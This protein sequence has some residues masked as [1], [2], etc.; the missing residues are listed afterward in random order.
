MSTTP[1]P[2]HNGPPSEPS[3]ARQYARAETWVIEVRGDLDLDTLPPLRKALQAAAAT[4]P[5]S[6]L[7]LAG[8]TF[9]DSSALNLLLLS[10]QAT[11]LRLAA[12]AQALSR[13][14]RITGAD[15]VLH[16]YPSVEDAT[17]S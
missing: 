1:E 4:H 8:V 9:A 16:I 6:V 11:D 14:F 17:S 7:D 5:V 10:S 2:H 12:P 13:L 3:I 15:Q